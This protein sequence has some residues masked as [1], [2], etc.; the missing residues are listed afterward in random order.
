VKFA[1]SESNVPRSVRVYSSSRMAAVSAW[2]GKAMYWWYQVETGVAQGTCPMFMN[3][4]DS[5]I[6][7]A[8]L[9]N[10]LKNLTGGVEFPFS[11]S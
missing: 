6:F 4:A 5:L 1:G 10:L 2:I 11:A 8:L 3:S 7:V 9:S